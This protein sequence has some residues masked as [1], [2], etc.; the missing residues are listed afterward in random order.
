MNDREL[1]VKAAP[2]FQRPISEALDDG[3]VGAPNDLGQ[4]SIEVEV[5]RTVWRKGQI[6]F[7]PPTLLTPEARNRNYGSEHDGWFCSIDIYVPCDYTGMDQVLEIYAG[8]DHKR[9]L[10]RLNE[11]KLQRAALDLAIS[12]AESHLSPS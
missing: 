7:V 3:C 12:K 2:Y 11:L 10:D 9:K 1:A 6:D 8:E 4:L 5:S